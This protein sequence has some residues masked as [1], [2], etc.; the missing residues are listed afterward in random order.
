MQVSF[1]WLIPLDSNQDYTFVY[2]IGKTRVLSKLSLI[3]LG[4]PGAHNR[5]IG[6]D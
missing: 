4:P 1:T 3:L 6:C 5:T 2:S